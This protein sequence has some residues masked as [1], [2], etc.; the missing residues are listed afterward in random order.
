MYEIVRHGEQSSHHML[1]FSL[2][3][4]S[5][6]NVVFLCEPFFWIIRRKGAL[7][8]LLCTISLFVSR[9][10]SGTAGSK[11]ELLYNANNGF[12][13]MENCVLVQSM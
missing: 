9:A 1:V 8:S 11:M 5:K 3:A 13:Y 4:R 10:S 7:V 6:L 12:L 2:R